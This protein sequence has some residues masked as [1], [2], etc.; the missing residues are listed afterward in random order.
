MRTTLVVEFAEDAN[1]MGGAIYLENLLAALCALPQDERPDVRIAFLG[2]PATPLAARL[3]AF[4]IVAPSSNSAPL[5]RLRRLHRAL[6][7]R[8]PAIGRLSRGVPGAVYFPAFDTRQT[9]RRNLYWIPDFQPLVLPEFF[10]SDERAARHHAMAAIAASRGT[11]LLSSRA[12]L[13]DLGRFFPDAMVDAR[14]WS[15]CSS[16][17]AGPPERAPPVIERLQ[18]P[19][20]YLVI[21]N[22]F[23]RHKDHATA[24]AALRL[25]AGQ[26]MRV[27]LVC[28]GLQS[29]RRDAGYFPALM[30]D[31]GAH[32]GQPLHLLGV[33]DRADQV[34]VMRCAAGIVQPSRFEG[35]STVIEDAKALGRPVIASDLAVHREQLDAYPEGQL[36]PTGE[37]AALA[38]AIA[39]L[40]PHVQP[41]PDGAAEQRAAARRDA[42]RLASGRDFLAILAAAGAPV[43]D[44]NSPGKPV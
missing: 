7:R 34:Q 25:L 3:M 31:A 15:F 27:P 36:F 5:A 26:G 9:W 39:A 24:F 42:R 14:V 18:L 33:I 20:K 6:V 28:T 37:P 38:A 8:W 43:P 40:W 1:W 10:E 32:I 4:P 11:L 35:W 22:Q 29:D 44:A 12:A 16:I 17:D 21:A 2:S 30:R 19:R 23:W 13:A 41:G